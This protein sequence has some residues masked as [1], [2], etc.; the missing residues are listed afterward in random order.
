MVFFRFAIL[1]N[2]A[3]SFAALVHHEKG[4][5][6][7][8]LTSVL[9]TCLTTSSLEKEIIVLDKSLDFSLGFLIPNLYE[10]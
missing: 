6:F 8:V 2:L 1:F 9:I 7:T 3:R 10:P 4:C 5:L